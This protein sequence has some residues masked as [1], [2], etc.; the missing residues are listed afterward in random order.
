MKNPMMPFEGK[1]FT[2]VDEGYSVLLYRTPRELQYRLLNVGKFFNVDGNSLVTSEMLDIL[3]EHG[4]LHLYEK[5][6]DGVLNHDWSY[7]V[8]VH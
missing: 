3:E 2:S 8:E 5:A 6:D 7:R 4:I 1:M